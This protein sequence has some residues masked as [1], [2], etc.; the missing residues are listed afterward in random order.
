MTVD[1]DDYAARY[2]GVFLKDPVYTDT[3]DVI[4]KQVP[5]NGEIQMLDLGCG[6]GNITYQLSRKYPGYFYTGVDPSENM[7]NIFQERF[8]GNPRIKV[9]D[10]NALEIPLGDGSV[11]C[12]VSNLALHHV[13]PPQRPRCAKE[14]ARAMR[15]GGRLVYADRFVSFDGPPDTPEKCKEIIDIFSGWAKFCLDKGAFEKAVRIL[16]QLPFDLTEDGEYPTS[17]DVWIKLLSAA[18]FEDFSIV[19]VQPEEFGIRVICCTLA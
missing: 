17:V 10:G 1:W 8:T 16:E 9:E 3:L 19:P 5:E 7:R 18:G 11:D 2:D 14:V 13:K 15:R 12:I 4:T 6:T